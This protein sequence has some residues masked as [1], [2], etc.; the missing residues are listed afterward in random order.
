MPALPS[1]DSTSPRRRYVIVD[2]EATCWEGRAP[3]ANEVIEIG[4]VAYEVGRGV[5]GEF[6]TFVRPRLRPVLSDF[7]KALT[8]IRQEDV[9][10]A[11]PFPQALE[12]F[13]AFAGSFAPFTLGAWGNYDR[14]QLRRDCKLHRVA[15]PFDSYV[16]LKQAF[17]RIKGC[18]P[19]GMAEALRRAGLALVGTHHRGIDD[20]RNIAR[21]LDHLLGRVTPEELEEAGAVEDR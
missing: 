10:G 3:A 5:A 17:A 8:T 13:R 12:A 9:D 4:A 19:G 18:P 11:P 2:L 1:E 16:N 7:C 14:N 6:Q 21:L 15:Y 20:V